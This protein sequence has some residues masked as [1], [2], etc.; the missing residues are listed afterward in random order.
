MVGSWSDHET[1]DRRRDEG[2]V[3]KAGQ[4]HREEHRA[5]HQSP[6]RE[7]L[8]SIA[9]GPGLLCQV[10][11]LCVCVLS[12]SYIARNDRMV[13]YVLLATHS[14]EVRYLDK[15]ETSKRKHGIRVR[16]MIQVV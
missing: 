16:G 12:G 10:R 11:P 14:N 7:V 8:L 6:R 2:A 1:A 3:R 15:L 4:L 13:S 9:Q 5:A